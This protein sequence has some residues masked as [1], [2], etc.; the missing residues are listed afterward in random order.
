[1]RRLTLPM[2]AVLFAAILVGGARSDPLRH[3][4]ASVSNRGHA[5]H[6]VA[7]AMRR[8]LH[9]VGAVGAVRIMALRA[10]RRYYRVG[11]RSG[12]DCYGVG[13]R[14]SR[15]DHFSLVCS[16]AFPSRQQPILDTSVFGA[17][18]GESLHVISV[19]G[20]AADGVATIGLENPAGLVARRIA[21][22]GNVYRLAVVP[23]GLTRLVAFDA[24][25]NVLFAVPE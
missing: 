1:M 15:G 12:D 10:R 7:P 6:H 16:A 11:R 13:A 22:I 9:R 19:E 8:V 25:G 4:L 14:S 5:T 17:D 18:A 20:F 2:L 21:V 3:N 23:P 24:Q